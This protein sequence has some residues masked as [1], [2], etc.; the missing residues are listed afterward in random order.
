MDKPDSVAGE[1]AFAVIG[2]AKNEL[3]IFQRVVQ[4]VLGALQTGPAFQ[5]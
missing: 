2:P 5:R 1:V 4:Q 3:L